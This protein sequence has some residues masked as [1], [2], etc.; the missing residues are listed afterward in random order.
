MIKIIDIAVLR[1]NKTFLPTPYLNIC[2]MNLDE[3]LSDALK[4][5]K[6]LSR[7]F[8]GVTVEEI[9]DGEVIENE[10][11]ECYC[12]RKSAEITSRP[13]KVDKDTILSD[14]KLIP[15]I[16]D[17]T[18]EKLKSGGYRTIKDLTTHPLWEGSAKN[19]LNL[20]EIGDFRNLQQEH[21]KNVSVSHPIHLHLSDYHDEFLLFDLE[22]MGLYNVPI[23]LFGAARLKLNGSGSVEV[24]QYLLRG[25]S[26]ELS[27]IVAFQ[28]EFDGLP[29]ITFNGRRFDV[30]YLKKRA[31]FYGVKHSFDRFHL[32]LLH[33]SRRF[34]SKTLPDYRLSTIETHVLGVERDIDMPGALV[35]EFYRS[36]LETGNAG[37]LIPIVEHNFQD[38]VSLAELFLHLKKVSL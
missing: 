7:K 33:F 26:E 6:E 11:G 35:P 32:D 5:K 18:Q 29:L 36:F 22:T 38:V 20:V 30:P 23:I 25:L 16:G 8:E 2:N 1:V 19:F 14:L 31:G 28:E 17:K 24:S 34:L 3:D 10:F 27:A 4:L 15:G 9:F 21:L 37:P 12:I 13:S